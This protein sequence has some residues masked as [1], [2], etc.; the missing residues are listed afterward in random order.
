M[1]NTQG[2]ILNPSIKLGLAVAGIA[3][4]CIS[5]AGQTKA[6][7]ADTAPIVATEKKEVL[8][9]S[10]H[11]WDGTKYTHYP[12]GKPELTML[13]IT[14]APHSA[15]PWHTHPVPN[16]GYILSGDLTI[17]DKASGKSVTY[18]AG[19]AFAESVDRVHRGES[20]DA[21]VVLLV[22]YSGTPGTPTSKPV[23]GEKREY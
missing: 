3:A 17:H 12:L 8:V 2:V 23:K 14:I 16:A 22:T 4:L 20:G 10:D 21:P 18:H 5:S 6:P 7:A 9:Q 15:L 19:Q 13:K 11:S 1:L